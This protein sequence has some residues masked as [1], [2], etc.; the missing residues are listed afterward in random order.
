[1]VGFLVAL[2]NTQLT[3]R[4]LREGR[5]ISAA[6]EVIKTEDER[7][8]AAD[9]TKSVM[10]VVDQT[11]AGLNFRTDRD[12]LEIIDDFMNVV[13]AVYEPKSYFDRLLRLTSLLKCSTRHRPGWFQLKRELFAL[14]RLARVMHGDRTT[15]LLFWRIMWAALR[16]G[17]GV[18]A[19]IVRL[20]AMYVHLRQQARYSLDAV[21]AQLPIHVE[22]QRKLA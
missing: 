1:M 12:R 3:R 14:M 20:I 6:G 16:K 7:L 4:L 21:T 9:A 10:L 17:K 13:C 8:A 22:L 18:F 19:Q 11:V 5:L 15:R 2:P